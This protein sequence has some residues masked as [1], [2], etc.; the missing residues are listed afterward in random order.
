VEEVAARQRLEQALRVMWQE[1]AAEKATIDA[2]AMVGEDEDEDEGREHEE[3]QGDNIGLHGRDVEA[4]ENM[5]TDNVGDSRGRDERNGM[6]GSAAQ[7]RPLHDQLVPSMCNQPTKRRAVLGPLTPGQTS[8]NPRRAF[9]DGHELQSASSDALRE[10][11]QD[12][13]S[14]AESSTRRDALRGESISARNASHIH[15]DDTQVPVVPEVVHQAALSRRRS[16]NPANNSN[17]NSSSSNNNNNNN[18]NHRA[19]PLPSL[20]AVHATK[21]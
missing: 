14:A 20:E 11:R 16:F 9:E 1:E 4:A 15:C 19:Q 7:Y 21:V 10:G 13:V 6:G 8:N 2:A 5:E 12:G 3:G 18:N 17:N